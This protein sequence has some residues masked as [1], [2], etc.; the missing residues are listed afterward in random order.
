LR[1]FTSLT[2][3]RIQLALRNRMFFFF[4]VVFPLGMFFLYAGIFAKGIPH[5][6]RF[7]LGPVIAFNV[8]GSFWGLS[9][10]LVMFRE[11]GILR[12]FHVTPI[13]AADMLASSVLA[14]CMLML[15]T[16]CLELFFASA[17]YHVSSLGNLVSV[18]V[19]VVVGIVSFGSLGLVIASITNTMQE[20]Q[21]L[22]QL[23][24][25]PLI[26]MSGATL[27][28]PYLPKAAQSVALFLPATYLVTGLQNAVY[29]AFPIW[30]LLVQVFSLTC[31]AVLTFFLSAQLFRWEPESKIPRKAKL[32]VLATALPFFLLGIWENSHGRILMQAQAAYRS[33][34]QPAKTEQ[35]PKAEQP[36][37]DSPSMGKLPKS[38]K[39]AQPQH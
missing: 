25:L 36:K 13:T 12:R 19:L 38:N 24:W 4:S 23:I 7:F 5:V 26:F 35:A 10:T 31:W 34:D 9:A 11:Q 15:P 28:I 18:I 20:T 30:K 17:I 21:V 37:G 33:L 32:W 6:V 2:R 16:V 1:N 22:N 29:S 27:P 8:M 14:N 39:N 3:M